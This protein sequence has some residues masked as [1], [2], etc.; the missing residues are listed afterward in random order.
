M[1]D[2]LS[3][4]ISSLARWFASN[5]QYHAFKLGK[6]SLAFD[7]SNSRQHQINFLTIASGVAIESGWFW[8]A[9][10]IHQED[11]NIF[12]FGGVA[13]SQA[14]QLQGALN[15]HIEGY[16]QRFYQQ[17]EPALQRAGQEA[18]V[19]FSGRQYIRHAPAE[20]W[21]VNYRSLSQ[22]LKR[23]D[24]LQFLNA[25]ALADY[26]QI[27]PLLEQGHQHIARLNQAFVDQ[28]TR[29]FKAF[30]DQVESNPLTEQQRK[31]CV[32]DEQHNLILAGAGTGKTSTMIGR[33]GYLVKAGLA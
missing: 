1:P 18:K 23:K 16:L 12:R 21:L 15:S 10:V 13:K 4:R 32:I 29:I 6:A 31:A 30:F 27:L 20:R 3:Y 14:S 2:M 5:S 26:Q 7:N 28:Q 8:N 19:L 17:F 9:L 11:G 22:G 25:D 24:C 33:A